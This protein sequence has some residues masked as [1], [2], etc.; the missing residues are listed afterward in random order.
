VDPALSCNRVYPLSGASGPVPFLKGIRRCDQAE[1][2]GLCLKPDHRIYKGYQN[3]KHYIP[4]FRVKRLCRNCSL[5]KENIRKKKEIKG[6]F[7]GS[8]GR[9]DRVSLKEKRYGL[10]MRRPVPDEFNAPKH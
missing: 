8:M 6:K 9:Y 7:F 10:S 5:T 1:P 2:A 3:S 4:G